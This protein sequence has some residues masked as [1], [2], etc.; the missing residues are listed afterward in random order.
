MPVE[1]VEDCEVTTTV[2][3]ACIV[4]VTE[5]TKVPLLG[6]DVDAVPSTDVT[7]TVAPDDVGEVDVV[8][9]IVVTFD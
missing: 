9:Q 3:F 2:P 8:D 5:E 7:V 1:R 6:C 4:E